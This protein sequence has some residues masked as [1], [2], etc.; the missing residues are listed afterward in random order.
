[1]QPGVLF[2]NMAGT[3]ARQ[4]GVVV[5]LSGPA[6]DRGHCRGRS[7]LSFVV[8]QYTLFLIDT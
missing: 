2:L 1:M 6:D 4:I 8:G 3:Q 7:R 5:V